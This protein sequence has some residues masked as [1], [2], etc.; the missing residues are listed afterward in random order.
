MAIHA[1]DEVI[2]L[3][4]QV[5]KDFSDL[6]STTA[7]RFLTNLEMAAW[8]VELEMSSQ[9]LGGT[10]GPKAIELRRNG[11]PAK[12]CVFVVERPGKVIVLHAF[13]KTCEGVDKKNMDTAKAR[14]KQ[15]LESRPVAD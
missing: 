5:S 6:D 1:T 3:S 13:K 15:W 4:K 2:F 8:G 10:V 14:Y 12:R 7:Q 9:H 11:R